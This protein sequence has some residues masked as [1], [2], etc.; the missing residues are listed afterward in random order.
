MEERLTSFLLDNSLY[1]SDLNSAIFIVLTAL[2]SVLTLR[3]FII[4]IEWHIYKSDKLQHTQMYKKIGRA[5]SYLL[6]GCFVVYLIVAFCTNIGYVQF[7]T[8]YLTAMLFACFV[9]IGASL[10]YNTIYYGFYC[11]C[12]TVWH[13][14]KKIF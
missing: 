4:G 9:G 13:W 2:F 7:L 3:F 11:P 12:A 14:L 8:T 5:V 6:F 1:F 10:L